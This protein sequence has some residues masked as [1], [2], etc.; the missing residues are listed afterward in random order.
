[1]LV[2]DRSAFGTDKR[3]CDLKVLEKVVH[4]AV[5]SREWSAER[6]SVNVRP[7]TMLFLKCI[8]THEFIKNESNKKRHNI[9]RILVRRPNSNNVDN[10][11]MSNSEL[12]LK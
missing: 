12:K 5:M 11:D 7:G 9:K 4:R 10:I 8:V 2:R 1:M 3:L 6:L